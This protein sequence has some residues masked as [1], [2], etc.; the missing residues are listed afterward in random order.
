MPY[1]PQTVPRQQNTK[2]PKQKRVFAAVFNRVLARTK[3]EET[4]FAKANAAAS[5]AGSDGKKA[6][7]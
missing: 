4:A 6:K 2:T 7:K 3:S 1:T 5:N